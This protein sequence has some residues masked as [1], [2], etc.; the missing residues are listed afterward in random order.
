MKNVAL[1]SVP[2]MSDLSS[3]DEA[4]AR[5]IEA[6]AV[7]RAATAAVTAAVNL[8]PAP[9]NQRQFIAEMYTGPRPAVDYTLSEDGRLKHERLAIFRKAEETE[10]GAVIALDAAMK[11]EAEAIRVA[12]GNGRGALAD[13]IVT[14]RDRVEEANVA[15]ATATRARGA[16][17]RASMAEDQARAAL[18]EA[19]ERAIQAAS[20]DGAAVDLKALRRAAADAA[21]DLEIATEAVR[22]AE[23]AIEEPVYQEQRAREGVGIAA[24]AVLYADFKTRFAALDAMVADFKLRA[25]TQASWLRA[26]VPSDG[27]WTAE[28][29]DDLRRADSLI[30]ELTALGEPIREIAGDDLFASTLAA[31][32]VD[33]A[34]PLPEMP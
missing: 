23:A 26:A 27:A 34:A 9:N 8:W 12:F 11:A 25:L 24:R 19:K 31:L 30:R 5:R 14:M 1:K 13:A 15:R 7:K 22:R 18:D 17:V 28:K 20:T 2:R 3:L 32:T 6:E 16:A 21:D 29:A 33:A 4:R 10:K